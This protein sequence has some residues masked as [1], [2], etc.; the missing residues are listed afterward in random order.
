MAEHGVVPVGA[1]DTGLILT[2]ERYDPR[3]RP[4]A[5]TGPSIRGVAAAV[6]EQVSPKT[7]RLDREYLV[8]DTGDA[9]EGLI[10]TA[11]PTV[12]GTQLGSNKKIVRPGDVII[13]RLRPYLRQ[14]AYVDPALAPETV[15]LVCSTEFYVLRRQDEASI[16]FLVPVLLSREVQEV[17]SASQEGGHHPRFNLATLEGVRVPA[18]TL[19]S[20]DDLS[21]SVEQAVQRARVADVTM[22][23]VVREVDDAA[24]AMS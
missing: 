19:E 20:R 15:E 2:P 1:L 21:R 18:R 6:S 13:S 12:S 11:K 3:R 7:A 9:R 10:L 22:S 5:G 4:P 24:A 8:L 23:S 17:L 14:V 16:A